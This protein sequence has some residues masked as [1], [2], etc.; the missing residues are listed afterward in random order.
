MRRHEFITLL[1]GAAAAWPLAAR[2][3][4]RQPLIGF[5]SSGASG[6]FAEM[7]AAYQQALGEVGYVAGK[8]V[9]IEYRWAEGRYDQL[10]ALAADLIG[11]RA[12]AANLVRSRVGADPFFTS[13]REQIVAEAARHS[14]A[15]M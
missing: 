12:L 13:R 10:P 6:P 4:Q 9:T 15:A 11:R 2:A 8:T 7:S 14:I 3:Q 5:L 1:G